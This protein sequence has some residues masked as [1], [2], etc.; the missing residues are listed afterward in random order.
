[1]NYSS[2]SPYILLFAFT[3]EGSFPRSLL[4]HIYPCSQSLFLY[5]NTNLHCIYNQLTAF[6][7]LI[8]TVT[9]CDGLAITKDQTAAYTANYVHGYLWKVELDPET[10]DAVET[11]VVMDKLVSPTAVELAYPANGTGDGAPKLFVVCCGEIEVGWVN[12]DARSWSDLAA[13]NESVDVTIVTTEEKAE[14]V[15]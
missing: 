2:L 12:D 15:S 1:M 4:F 8:N 7:F 13:I 9:H 14:P 6:L 3:L 11:R 10:G 5:T